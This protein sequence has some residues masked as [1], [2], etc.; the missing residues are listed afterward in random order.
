VRVASRV[1]KAKTLDAGKVAF[2]QRRPD[3]AAVS[4][5][6]DDDSIGVRAADCARAQGLA[7]TQIKNMRA[8]R[9]QNSVTGKRPLC[10][11]LK[12]ISS[13]ENPVVNLLSWR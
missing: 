11:P 1:E 5:I 10:E 8:S 13:L 12:T 2:D 4:H 9:F 7:A 3:I 6:G